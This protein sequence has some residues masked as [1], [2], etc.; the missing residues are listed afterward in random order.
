M[1]MMIKTLS[2]RI[3]V[4]FESLKTEEKSSW[5][6]PEVVAVAYKRLGN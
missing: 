5:V 4:A 3:V 6:I 2:G 1:N